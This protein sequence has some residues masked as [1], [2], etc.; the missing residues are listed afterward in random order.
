MLV[1]HSLI[2]YFCVESV[3][4]EH[5]LLIMISTSEVW[6]FLAEF[7]IFSGYL[8]PCQL[9]V[10]LSSIEFNVENERV[11]L[12]LTRKCISLTKK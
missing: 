8:F 12:S 1:F 3:E 9:V 2:V 7:S 10:L 4:V 5:S 11:I 6:I